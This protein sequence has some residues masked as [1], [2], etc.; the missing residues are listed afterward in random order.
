MDRTAAYGDPMTTR[1]KW[2]IIATM[3]IVAYGI[4]IWWII[5]GPVKQ[6]RDWPEKAWVVERMKMHG[7]SGC[8]YDGKIYTFVRDGRRCKL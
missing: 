5:P 4:V 2:A 8:E 6:S 3:V 7:I 1:L